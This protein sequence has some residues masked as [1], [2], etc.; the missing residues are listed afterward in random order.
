MKPE[1]N[2]PW[3]KFNKLDLSAVDRKS[4]KVE[5]ATAK[6]AH[7]FLVSRI[8]NLRHIRRHL[9]GWLMLLIILIG[10]NALQIVYDQAYVSVEQPADD[11]AYAEGVL[12]PLNNLNPLFA[13][14]DAEISASR[15]MFSSLLSYDTKG[16][17]QGDVAQSY[18]IDKTGTVYTINLKPGLKWHDGKPLTAN[19]VV[20]TVLTMQNPKVGARQ[21]SS[22]QNINVQASGDRQVIFTLP[23]NY[24]PFASALTFPIVPQHVL[25]K[26]PLEDLQEDNFS[27]NP[28]GSGPFKYVDLQT[29]DVGKGKTALLLE[30]NES[31]S[32]IAPRL[33]RFSLYAY[34]NRDELTKGIEHRE[35]NAASGINVASGSLKNI[36]VPINNGL[37]AIYK[38][39]SIIL[40]DE[41]VRRALTKGID[42]GNI[43]DKLGDKKPLEGPIINSQTP[44]A[45]QVMQPEYDFAT[46]NKQLAKSGWKMGKDNIRHK[47]G[48]PLELRLVAVD[49]ANYRKVT[50]LLTEQWRK[51]GVKVIPQL[52][53]PQ[54]VQ[55]IILRPR[56]YDILVYELSQGGDPDGYAFWHSSQI[57]SSGLNFANYD[58]PAADDALITARGRS[59][60]AVRDAKYATF[61]AQWAKDV[62]AMA[63]YRSSLQYTTTDGTQALSSTDLLVDPADRFYNIAD[64]SAEK[65]TTYNTP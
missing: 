7:K 27:N 65:G 22:W 43:R 32:S 15:L 33:G 36:D 64:W 38:T 52:V 2:R 59:N 26:I 6:H 44:L 4:K 3:F 61:A 47:D 63:L 51:L 42:R 50:K 40:K 11:V 29:V 60:P 37:Y 54:Q 41:S 30:R 21:F 20:F 35:I 17:L 53:D 57:S 12:G 10:L 58:S 28:V 24:A 25:S 16:A 9:I 14:S 13:A 39:D 8:E 48:E 18:S 34:S 23:T 31:Y 56:A 46:A 19:D 62:P 49:T 5:I 55:Q 1:K 45:S